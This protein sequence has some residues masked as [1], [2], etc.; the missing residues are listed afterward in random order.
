MSNNIFIFTDIKNNFTQKFWS[1]ISAM[2]LKP[3]LTIASLKQHD[4]LSQI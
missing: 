4:A 1:C 3:E 2:P